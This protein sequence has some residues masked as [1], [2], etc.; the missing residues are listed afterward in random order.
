MEDYDC[1][2]EADLAEVTNTDWAEYAQW[3]ETLEEAEDKC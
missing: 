3:L 2:P 1:L